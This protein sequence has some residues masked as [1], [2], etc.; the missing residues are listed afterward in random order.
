M[1]CPHCGM[2]NN[3]FG[4]SL[5]GSSATRQSA[6]CRTIERLKEQN[7]QKDER[8][9]VLDGLVRKMYAEDDQECITNLNWA[10]VQEV[11]EVFPDLVPDSYKKALAGGKGEG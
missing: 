7:S 4:E 3:A 1:N 10:T 8:V 5:C 11:W 9:R 6:V 2:E